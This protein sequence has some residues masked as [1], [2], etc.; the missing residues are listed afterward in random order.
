[1]ADELLVQL[2][3]DIVAAHVGHNAVPVS[4]IPIM[5][6]SVHA[7]LAGLNQPSTAEPVKPE[8]A[9]AIR[10]SVRP[11][12]IVCLEDGKR[13]KALKRYLR[14]H[15]DMSPEEYRAKWGLPA[16]Y[17][18]VAPNYSKLRQELARKIGL[19]KGTRA[20]AAPKKAAPV[21]RASRGASSGTSSRK[22][23]S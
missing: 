12:Y 5:I 14:T 7:A 2:S 20:A 11:D 9:V 17:P 6:A 21:K 3:A 10:S 23:N 15:Y 1:M 4:D 19:G 8:P 16:T 13:L 22:R 18:M